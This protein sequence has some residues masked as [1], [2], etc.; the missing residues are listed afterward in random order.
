MRIYCRN[1]FCICRDPHASK[2]TAEGRDA[3][4]HAVT[5]AQGVTTAGGIILLEDRLVTSPT[6]HEVEIVES[7]T[8]GLE[9]GDR[10]VV[11]LGGDD[12]EISTAGISAYFPLAGQECFSIPEKFLWARIRDGELLPRGDVVL[13]ERDDAAMQRYAFNSSPLYAPDSLY[14]RGVAAANREDPTNDGARAHD[15]VTL[16]Y[17]RVVRSGPD[18][19]ADFGFTPGTIVAFSPSYSCTS[20]AR[21]VRGLDGKFTRR[22]LALV[23]SGEIFFSVEE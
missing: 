8:P 4:G 1:G 2:A 11:Y 15:S 17:A 3:A 5:V 14:Q 7:A 18:V 9:P 13:V 10:V 21:D 23:D 22:F 6:S 19:P 12:G 16:Q 20:M